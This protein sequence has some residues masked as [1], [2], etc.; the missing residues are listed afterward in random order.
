[1]SQDRFTEVTKQSWL[2]RVGGAFAGVLVGLLMFIMAFPLL[3]WNEGRAVTTYKTLKEG[4]SV[5]VSVSANQV[6]PA[7]A[8]SL[9]HVTGPANTEAILKDADFDIS[10]N[11]LKLKRT[12]EMLQWKQNSKSE[13]QKKLGGGTETVTEY[14]YSKEWSSN[15]VN[16]DHFK[17][18]EGHRNPTAMPYSS[19]QQSADKATLGAFTLSPR[20]LNQI[21]SFEPLVITADMP[22][23]KSVADKGQVF[24]SGYYIGEDPANAQIGDLRVSFAVVKPTNVS[25]VAKQVGDTFEA[26]KAKAKGSIEMLQVGTHSAEAMIQAAQDSNVST[27]W[28]LRLAGFIC[29]L[30]GLILIF[31]PLSVIADV[32][33]IAGT[34]VGAGTGLIAFLVAAPASLITIGIAWIVYRPLLGIALMVTAVGLTVA[35]KG[36]LKAAKLAKNAEKAE[37][38][39]AV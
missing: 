35:L 14:W 38:E 15:L 10:V 17:K 6:D 28:L 18:P 9:I 20:L 11:A 19:N 1:M 39:S 2:S 25:V 23:P 26:Y 21:N 22:L 12:V 30:V 29:M 16:S 36:K 4:G 34:I 27:T 5:V 31:K 24:D 3:F 32:L 37:V 8:G 7:H 33:P 13:T